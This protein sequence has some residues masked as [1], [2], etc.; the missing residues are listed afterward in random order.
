MAITQWGAWSFDRRDDEIADLSWQG[1]V[2]LR[3]IRAV[4]RDHNWATGDLRITR[5]AEASGAL[6][7]E[8]SCTDLGAD[9]HGTVIVFA[10]GDSF[11]VELDLESRSPFLS[12]RIGLVVLHPQRLA[13]APLRVL[14]TD[15]SR[16]STAFPRSVSPHQPVFDIRALEWAADQLTVSVDFEGDTF[17]MEDQ[18]NWSDASYKTYSRPLALPFP[19]E[20][21]AGGTIA[22]RV[23]VSVAGAVP[24]VSGDNTE[25]RIEAGGLFPQIL[26]SASSAP[27]SAPDL[28][29]LGDGVLI[30]LDLASTNWRAALERAAAAGRPLD[31]RLTIPP[32]HDAQWGTKIPG[33]LTGEALARVLSDAAGALAPHDVLRIAA[34]DPISHVTEP[35]AS[36]ALR[37]A[38]A[39]RTIPILEGARSHF[40]ELNREQERIVTDGDGVTFATTPLFH[41][42]G[43]EQLFES[44][45]VQQV[46][47]KQA[48]EIAHGRPVHIGPVTLVPR[49]NNVATVP[50]SSP[51]RPDLVE[52]YGTE[53][54]GSSDPRQRSEAFAAWTIASAAALA[55]PGV[56]SLTYF[57]QWGD[58]GVVSTA[59]TELPVAMALRDLA[60]LAQGE[61]FTGD[62]PDGLIWALG[63]QNSTG[64]TALV[65]NLDTSERTV[66][67]RVRGFAE[68]A[69]DVAARN[70]RKVT[71]S[72]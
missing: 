38:L 42:L 71:L 15:D 24:S 61:R 36:A 48:T 8:V 19:Y 68:L 2:V 62:S 60:A 47:A 27:D 35:W 34:F 53:F 33:G 69:V 63:S 49:F 11:T 66:A 40:T 23:T 32:S 9:L 30:E 1:A 20:V 67:L 57:E 56:E 46:I 4:V 64:I 43:D 25:I 3:S 28:A 44:I 55:Q 7:L 37:H 65:A 70:Y 52:G 14:H 18:R 5:V 51:S 58:R 17:E 29:Q 16:E 39:G 31:V 10:D 26:L 22:Q 6:R 54:T 50:P 12:N 13:G 72:A 45:A 59:G 41:T 21:A